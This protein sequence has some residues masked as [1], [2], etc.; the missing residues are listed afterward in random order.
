MLTLRYAF[1]SAYLKAQE[2]RLVTSE[3]IDRLATAPNIRDALAAVR[4]TDVG[5]YLEEVPVN[6]FDDLDEYLW[7]YLA[8]R[9]AYIQSFKLLPQDVH[10]TLRAYI[11]KYDILNIKAALR[12]LLASKKAKMIPLGVIHSN[13]LL[14]G[15]SAAEN[16][17]D[18]IRILSKCGLENYAPALEKHK[19]D[20]GSKPKVL[21]EATLD[22]QYYASML[23]VARK[24]QDGAVLTRAL[25]L[26]IDLAN[27]QI[28]LRAIIGGIGLEAAGCTIAGG[29]RIT[30]KT[31][32][33][34]LSLRI[35]D[36]P[37]RLEDSQYHDIASEVS[38]SY[39][40]TKSITA[41]D[42]IVDK[43][44][45]RML[46]EVLSPRVLSPLVMAWYL[47]LKEVEIRNL[48]LVLK[49]I[50][51]GMPVQDIKNYLV[52]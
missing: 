7:R 17:D 42:E 38:A 34:L 6:S 31:A 20:K 50:V 10:K 45:F 21:V 4:E 16:V 40:R 19:M 22:G 47:V 13:G 32:N 26:M 18:I 28:V 52:L 33:E 24:T 48:R 11:V 37:D 5:S 25:G 36:I 44:K 9:F 41:V 46:K 29:Y 3:H 8:Q 1:I 30:D 2:A 43:H 27:L 49:A 35:A 23:N 14:D 15:L 39:D 51:D 12:G